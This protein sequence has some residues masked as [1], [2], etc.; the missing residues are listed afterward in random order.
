MPNRA[1]SVRR[2]S[3]KNSAKTN[4]NGHLYRMQSRHSSLHKQTRQ[5][6]VVMRPNKKAA[7]FPAPPDCQ[8]SDRQIMRNNFVYKIR[9]VDRSA[10]RGI[11]SEPG[12]GWP[13]NMCSLPSLDLSSNASAKN[14]QSGTYHLYAMPPDASMLVYWLL[15]FPPASRNADQ[16]LPPLAIFNR[17]VTSP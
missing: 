8:C 6:P 3:R 7:K 15:N 17:P 5:P 12:G 9:A 10:A 1:V 11:T 2:C 16:P 14:R 4:R 13:A